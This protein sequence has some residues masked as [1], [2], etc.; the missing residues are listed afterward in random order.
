MTGLTIVIF[1][2]DDDINQVVTD[3][4][5]TLEEACQAVAKRGKLEWIGADPYGAGEVFF[6]HRG[7]SDE[8]VADVKE[9]VATDMYGLF[10]LYE[11]DFPIIPW[12]G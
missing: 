2:T 6:A 3:V 12:P 10:Q 4:P 8:E 1:N 11:A 9:G 7:L 5:G